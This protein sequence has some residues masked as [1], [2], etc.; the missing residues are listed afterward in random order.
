MR[1]DVSPRRVSMAAGRPVTVTVTVTNT[2]TV[3]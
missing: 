2:G 3:S 1:V